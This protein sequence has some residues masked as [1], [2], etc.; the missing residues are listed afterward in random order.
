MTRLRW[1]DLDP[2]LSWLGQ[3]L[4]GAWAWST[5]TRARRIFAAPLFLHVLVYTAAMMSPPVA[6]AFVQAGNVDPWLATLGVVD[7][8]G[9]PL[10][11]Y[12]FTT[13]FGTVLDGGTQLG[14]ATL[15]QIEA[16]CFISLGGWSIWVLKYAISFGFL[17]TLVAPFITVV[18]DITSHAIPGIAAIAAVV[19]AFIVA[20]NVMRGNTSRAASQ[21]MAALLVVMVTGVLMHSP[22]SWAISENGPLKTG[23]NVAISL[24][25]NS[26]ASSP[27]AATYPEKWQGELATLFVRQPLQM[28]NLGAIADDTPAC[29]Q[30]WNA[31]VMSGD[32]DQIKDRIA[33]CGSP[34]SA[35]M[36]A[37]V[38]NPNPGQLGTGLML[39]L[40]I[41][42]FA[43]FCFSMA[44]HIIGEFFRAVANGARLLW[45]AAVGVIPG[46]AQSN[47]VNT[48]VA[49]MFSAVAM[50]AYVTFTVLVG[51]VVG[52]V[53]ARLGNGA[54]AMF[55]ALIVMI[56]A[57]V[58]VSKVSR[59][60]KQSSA[61]TTAN[62]LS[63]IGAPP[64]PERT[65]ILKEKSSGFLRDLGNIGTGVAAGAVGAAAVKR[66]PALAP[67]MQVAGT[68]LP[69]RRNIRHAA[70]GANKYQKAAAKAAKNA[71]PTAP[72]SASS[73]TAPAA[74]GPTAAGPTTPVNMPPAGPGGAAATPSTTAPATS[75]ATTSPAGTPPSAT[76]ANATSPG[77]PATGSATPMTTAAAGASAPPAAPPNSADATSPGRPATAALTPLPDPATRPSATG[78][79]PHPPASPAP[80]TPNA[81]LTSPDATSP[82]TPTS[83]G[84][85]AG[86]SPFEPPAPTDTVPPDPTVARAAPPAPRPVTGQAM[87]MPPDGDPAAAPP[88]PNQEDR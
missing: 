55:T 12:T 60:L 64:A 34:Q 22:I 71:P 61:Q 14:L 3:A 19:A 59:G 17:E 85:P 38:D 33:G 15:L 80:I 48:S 46:A 26:P 44:M 27:Q 6:Q 18:Q 49:L 69:H 83:A 1:A 52:A 76:A 67:A 8:Y 53:F 21:T 72:A 35:A 70:R 45:D 78:E 87:P 31:G 82:P 58:G 54:A 74:P 63:G 23:R 81:A 77:R 62:L 66:I 16:A 30:A 86:P 28:W 56:F 43:V 11:R 75:A 47:L 88:A 73:M 7:S 68:Y 42:T 10:A 32:Q 40:F 29:A 5:A 2:T 37:T 84:A 50:F 65:H 9:V 20:I 36:K 51:G 41:L 79:D 24:A 25:T 57:V 4:V 39:L 13:D